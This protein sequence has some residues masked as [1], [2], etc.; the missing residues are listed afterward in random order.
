MTTEDLTTT[1]MRMAERGY[2]DKT[3]WPM[4]A[5][6]RIYKRYDKNDRILG[7]LRHRELATKAERQFHDRMGED[8]DEDSSDGEVEPEVD[9][10]AP[11]IGGEA[12]DDRFQM[13]ME[14][15]FPDVS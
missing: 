5:F 1:A 12:E 15:L 6:A 13:S 14:A 9:D 4:N 8:R 10:W 11:W 2:E 3:N 7:Y